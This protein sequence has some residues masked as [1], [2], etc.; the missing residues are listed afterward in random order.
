M[1]E[2]PVPA[3]TN[4]HKRMNGHVC[5]DARP[6]HSRLRLPHLG[7]GIEH[8]WQEYAI[9]TASACRVIFYVLWLT[10]AWSDTKVRLGHRSA[11]PHSIACGLTSINLTPTSVT[12]LASRRIPSGSSYCYTCQRLCS[13]RLFPRCSLAISCAPSPVRI[14]IGTKKLRGGCPLQASCRRRR[15]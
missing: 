1:L 10:N 2:Q 5:I 15:F 12:L 14:P 3:P 4:T 11:S 6:S 7:N 8:Y 9:A 13:C